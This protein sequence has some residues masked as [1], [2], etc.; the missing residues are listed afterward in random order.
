MVARNVSGPAVVFSFAIAAIASLFSG[1]HPL[2]LPLMH[3]QINRLLIIQVSVTQSS[4]S[5]F[6]TQQVRPVCLWL[7]IYHRISSNTLSQG[8]A[9]MY[10]YVTVGEFIA[11]VIGWNM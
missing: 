2:S 1:T 10:S 6:R 11:F 3:Y 7:T 5:E 8:S 4:G 9:Y